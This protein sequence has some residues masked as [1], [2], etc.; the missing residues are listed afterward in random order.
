MYS[1]RL[2]YN[3]RDDFAG[4]VSN[5]QVLFTDAYGQVDFNASY[6][7]TEDLML[8]F[9][10]INLTEEGGYV[11]WGQEDR[12]AVLSYAGRRMYLGLNYKF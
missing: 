8:N 1:A 12:L 6:S 3:W 10:A 4:S 11:Y 5:G 7:V 9:S 2:S